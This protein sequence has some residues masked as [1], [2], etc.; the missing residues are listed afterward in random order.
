MNFVFLMCPL[1]AV[2][3]SKDTSYAFM[4]GAERMGHS[5]YH[6]SESG[7][8]LKEGRVVLNV[9][10][11]TPEPDK[12][13]PF[14]IGRV[15]VLSDERVDAVFIRTDPPFDE[16]YLVNTWLLEALPGH[17]PVINRPAGIRAA[18]EKIWAT[19]FTDITPASVVTRN[20]KDCLEFLDQY[21]EII[22]KPTN[23]YGGDSVFYLKKGGPNVHVTFETLTHDQTEHI[24]LQEFIR[25]ARNGDKRILLLD[26]EALGAVLRVHAPGDHRNNFFS[27]GSPEPARITERDHYIIERIKPKLKELGLYFVGIDVIGD[28]LIEVNVTSPTCIQEMNRFYQKSL[29]DD[30]IRFV[31]GL[32]NESRA[33]SHG[34]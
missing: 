29:E 6:L 34:L 25:E 32:V 5:V 30:V 20:K 18:N 10:Q 26:G 8:I 19:Q 3:P 4:L 17:I 21:N 1:D 27:G 28:Y 15:D 2:V 24:I 23:G 31:E 16:K 7:I 11:V 14:L 33:G 22:A 12:D 9:T 13:N